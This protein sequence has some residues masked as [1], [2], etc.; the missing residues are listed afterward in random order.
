MDTI[1]STQET[2]LDVLRA[3]KL[4]NTTNRHI[5]D[6]ETN[7]ARRILHP[8]TNVLQELG[9]PVTNLSNYT[10]S[11][12]EH[13]ALINSLRHVYP[14]RKLD[15]LQFVCNMEYFYA[16]LLNIKTAYRHYEQKPSNEV[17]RHQFTSRMFS[18][19]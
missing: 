14:R 6:P 19:M 16:R 12:N 9:D 15:G 2:K 5:L 3:K 10:L 8:V 1:E 17:V 18:S 7:C 11:D 4:D 13:A